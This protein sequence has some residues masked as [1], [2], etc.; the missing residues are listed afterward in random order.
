M[1]PPPEGNW[2]MPKDVLQKVAGYGPDVE[3]NRKAARKIMKSLGYG[4]NNKLKIVVSTR[5]IAFYRDPAVILMDRLKEI[6]F[7]PT[8]DNVETS[9]WHPKVARKDYAVG[10][11]ATGIGVDDPDANLYV[12]SRT[13]PPERDTVS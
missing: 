12:R 6:Y 5:N 10:L 4:P 11:N 2:G 1:M 3:A 13:T 9:A 7:E 8:L